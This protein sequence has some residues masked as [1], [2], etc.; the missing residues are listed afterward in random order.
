MTMVARNR[1]RLRPI[2]AASWC[3]SL[4]VVAVVAL[5]SPA[6]AHTDLV[7]TSP[8]AASRVATPPSEV[9][10]TFTEEIRSGL[11]AVSLVIDGSGAERLRLSTGREAGEVVAEVPASVRAS[12][13][14]DARWVVNYRVTASDS[15]PIAG[16]VEFEVAGAAPSD[17]ASPASRGAD[18][19]AEAQSAAEQSLQDVPEQSPNSTED[20]GVPTWLVP[21]SV[22]L[23]LGVLVVAALRSLGRAE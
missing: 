16:S 15:H 13:A 17:T 1:R 21:L 14:P 22:V 10:L 7:A 3:A 9:R 2:A 4:I 11:G 23:L 6:Q 19:G 5:V 12:S 18:P 20:G 8:E